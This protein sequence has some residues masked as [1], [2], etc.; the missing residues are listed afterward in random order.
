M[1]KSI[2]QKNKECYICGRPDVDVHHVFYGTANRRLSDEDGCI[3]Y[4]CREHH[5]GD[6]GIH[7]NPELDAMI[8][9]ECQI[10]WMRA[11]EK[12]VEEFRFR[13]GKSYL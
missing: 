4:L 5:T 9:K 1:R 8:K 2:L 7:F 6:I 11:N 3:V 13:F 10:A 12:S